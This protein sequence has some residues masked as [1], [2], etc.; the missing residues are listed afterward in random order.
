MDGHGF[1]EALKREAFKRVIWRAATP[2]RFS[3]M[4]PVA[5]NPSADPSTPSKRFNV[6]TLQ[7]LAGCFLWLKSFCE[8]LGGAADEPP[9]GLARLSSAW[10]WRGLWWGLLLGAILLFCGQSSKFIYIDF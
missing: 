3:S 2:R 10:W 4:R 7:R 1:I 6:S 5:S 8:H 9:L